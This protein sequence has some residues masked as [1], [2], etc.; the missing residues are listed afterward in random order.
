MTDPIYLIS[1]T[2]K[3]NDTDPLSDHVL[4][5]LNLIYAVRRSRD[6]VSL[7]RSWHSNSFCGICRRQFHHDFNFVFQNSC[8]VFYAKP[9]N[10]NF[11]MTNK[12]F[13]S[14]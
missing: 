13:D 4:C 12:Y 11:Y 1:V 8:K 9:I 3:V 10:R 5:S 7:L 6:L 2:G 14:F